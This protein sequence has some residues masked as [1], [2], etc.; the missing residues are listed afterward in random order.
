MDAMWAIIFM[1]A[2]FV[3]VALGFIIYDG[4]AKRSTKNSSSRNV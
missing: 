4:Y 2:A 1:G 3:L